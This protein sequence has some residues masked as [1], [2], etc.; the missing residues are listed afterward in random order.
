MRDYHDLGSG[1]FYSY[2]LEDAARVGVIIWRAEPREPTHRPYD[3]EE[4]PDPC[5]LYLAHAICLF[6]VP[7]NDRHPDHA[8]WTLHSL[9]PLTISPSIQMYSRTAPGKIPSYHGH[10]HQGRWEDA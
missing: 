6:A 9:D 2:V 4:D 5:H 3:P 7:E 10:I 1:F 8:K